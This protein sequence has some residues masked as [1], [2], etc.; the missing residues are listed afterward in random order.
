ME[1][2]RSFHRLSC[3]NLCSFNPQIDPLLFWSQIN[4][5]RIFLKVIRVR[6]ITF[7]SSTFYTEVCSMNTNML[8]RKQVRG[9][10]SVYGFCILISIYIASIRSQFRR[11]IKA[12]QLSTKFSQEFYA[13][14]CF[15]VHV[16]CISSFKCEGNINMLC[17]SVIIHDLQFHILILTTC[18]FLLDILIR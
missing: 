7:S 1:Q 2:C 4:F 15:Q 17:A 10:C 18:I 14:T 11:T 13:K 3:L 12:T 5:K 8:S 16:H 9:D 6:M